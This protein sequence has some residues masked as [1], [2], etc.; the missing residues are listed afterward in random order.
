M[1]VSQ[2]SNAFRMFLSFLAHNAPSFNIDDE[3][4]LKQ[5]IEFDILTWIMRFL[6]F[7][8]QDLVKRIDDNTFLYSKQF[9]E[10]LAGLPAEGEWHYLVIEFGKYGI[11]F[12]FRKYEENN[13]RS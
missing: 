4:L 5:A 7:C 10:E 6:P 8:W 9:V 13:E 11:M 2:F 12:K 3:E 1:N